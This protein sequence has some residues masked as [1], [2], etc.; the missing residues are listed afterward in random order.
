MSTVRPRTKVSAHLIRVRAITALGTTV[1]TEPTIRSVE[2]HFFD[3][4][5]NNGGMTW[6]AKAGYLADMR[7]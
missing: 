2:R 6:H 4:I 1:Q 5:P 3:R 7:C